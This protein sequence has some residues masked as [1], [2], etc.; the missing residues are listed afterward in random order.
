MVASGEFFFLGPGLVS[1]AN[2]ET[3]GMSVVYTGCMRAQ[4]SKLLFHT[5]D[6]RNPVPPDMYETL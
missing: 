5:V 2:C 6:G 1:G 4:Q 3:S